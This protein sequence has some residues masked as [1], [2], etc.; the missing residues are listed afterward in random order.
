MLDRKKCGRILCW[1]AFILMSS[2]QSVHTPT[3]IK[4][5]PELIKQVQDYLYADD[6]EAGRLLSTLSTRPIEELEAVLGEV[7]DGSFKKPAPTGMLPGQ[8]IRVGDADMSYGLYVP[9]SYS[10]SRRYPLVICLHGAGFDG[11]T[12]LDR[13]QPRLGED[14]ILACPTLEDGSWWTREG[15]ELVLAVLSKVSREYRIDP[16]RVFLTGM[17]NGGIGTYLIGLNHPDRFAALIPMAGVLPHALFPL[18]DNAKNIS[19]YLIHGSQDQVMPV[20]YSRDVKAYLEQKGYTVV[21]REHEQVHPVA[22]GH[23]FP[24]EELPAL[25]DWLK[26]QARRPVP[27]EL[28]VVHDRDHSGRVYWTRIEEIS[29]ETGS[30]WASEFDH[31]EEERLQQGA[32]AR[33]AVKADGNT[34][35]VTAQNVV[36][37]GLLLNRELVDFSK[38]IK[39]MTNREISFEGRVKPDARTL[40]EEIRR[41]PDMRQPVLATVEIG[42][43]PKVGFK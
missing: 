6:Q 14:Y 43:P 24:R 35:S 9:A 3:A 29:P 32:Y 2:C 25:V 15:E 20:Q 39:V 22:G 27:Q 26:V 37:Y 5:S 30:F 11:N 1:L 7:L 18:L 38:P 34:F 10:P 8:S 13:W 17:S 33:M 19:F 16:D 40:L 41:R 4:A 28:V 23:F 12:Y 31:G 36:R 21:Y 42:I